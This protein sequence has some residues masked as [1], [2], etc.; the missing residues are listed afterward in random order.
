[1]DTNSP[2]NKL[3]LVTGASGYIGGRLIPLLI[4]RGY[5]VRCLVRDLASL[6][7]RTWFQQVETAVGDVTVRKSLNQAMD[8]VTAAYYLVHSMV[9]GPGYDERDI[10]AARNF[11][12]TAN[13]AGLEQIIYLG[14]LVNPADNIGRHMRSRLMT[15]DTLRQGSVPVTEFRASVIIGSGSISFE[16]IRFL[17]EQLPILVVPRSLDHRAQ[18]IA[19]QNVLDYLLAALEIPNCRGQTYEIGGTDVLSYIEI[20]QMYAR[21]RGLKRWMPILP[22]FPL[23]LLAFGAGKLTPVPASITRPLIDG[24]RSDSVVNDE[25]ALQIFPS[26]ARL[27]Y[28][29]AIS[30]SLNQLNPAQIEPIWDNALNSIKIIKHAGFFILSQQ[31]SLEVQPEVVYRVLI[32]L[33]GKRGWLYLNTLWQLRGVLD[34]LFGGPGMRGRRDENYLREGDIIDFYRV[35]TLEQ[36]RMMRLRAELK[37]PGS[38]WMDWHLK[39]KSN[40]GLLF[41]QVMYFAPKGLSGF[42]YWYVLYPVHR[43]V[44]SGLFK[45]LVY[46]ARQ[47]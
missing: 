30:A 36:N 2:S 15:G 17:T 42:L 23:S 14:G 18:P 22:A 10:L 26:I 21:V 6:T 41:S 16:M 1:M 25:Q 20:M 13:L 46:L 24:M 8:G 27:G 40:G 12:A 19:I 45:K 33:G 47:M 31:I 38:G 34:C 29:E 43:L 4:Q 37:A 7:N 5:G 32:E 44:F 3:V 35:E 28:K 9:S 39:P 11:A